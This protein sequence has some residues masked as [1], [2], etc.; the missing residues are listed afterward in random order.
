ME[1]HTE[2]TNDCLIDVAGQCNCDAM[3]D[4]QIDAELLEKEEAND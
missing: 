1:K 4:K 3:T 2:H